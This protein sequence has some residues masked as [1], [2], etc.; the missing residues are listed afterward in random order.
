M[1]FASDTQKLLDQ[2]QKELDAANKAL[3]K[4][5]QKDSKKHI[6]LAKAIK[7][8]EDEIHIKSAKAAKISQ[9]QDAKLMD[10]AKLKKEQRAWQDQYSYMQ[11]TLASYLSKFELSLSNHE[12]FLYQDDLNKLKDLNLEQDK[13]EQ[14]LIKLQMQLSEKAIDRIFS[15]LKLYNFEGKAIDD[16]GNIY[17]GTYSKLGPLSYFQSQDQQHFLAVKDKKALVASGDFNESFHCLNSTDNKNCSIVFDSTFANAFSM[18]AQEESI[19]E[20]LEKG[21]I[22]IYPILAFG[23]LALLVAI[24]KFIQIYSFRLGSARHLEKIVQTYQD[25]GRTKALELIKGKTCL[26]KIFANILNNIE[27][28]VEV[29]E[30]LVYEEHLKVKAKLSKF[31]YIIA[32]TASI[33]PLLGLLGTVT[34]II[35]TFKLI[36]VFGSAD[37]KMLSSGISEALISTEI[38]LIVAIP[39]LVLFALLRRK[40]LHILEDIEKVSVIFIN[41]I[42]NWP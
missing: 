35:K 21:G 22:W 42:K 41:R 19:K 7:V 18:M 8:L 26:N 31:L 6:K 32:T 4:F 3:A 40:V 34:G 29:L 20:H 39:S 30:E 28:N 25:Q 37:P 33:A 13:D 14:E 10:F 15:Q 17:S 5:Y 2:S 27:Q 9:I 23:S 1:L 12:R 38:G 16:Q 24:L 36:M 11:N